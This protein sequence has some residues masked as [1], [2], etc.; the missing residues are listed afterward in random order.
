MSYG[1]NH[2]ALFRH[3]AGY[4]DRLLKGAN[5]ADLPIQQPTNVEFVV[6]VRT[7]KAL[8]LT[9]PPSILQRATEII[10]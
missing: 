3:A 5:A 6:N 10:Q 4:V 2:P 7:A 9:I 8:G 1:P